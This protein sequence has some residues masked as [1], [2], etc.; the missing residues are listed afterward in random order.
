MVTQTLPSNE[1]C[2]AFLNAL[3]EAATD[4]SDWEAQFIESNTD[5]EFFTD[6]QK[7]SIAKM[8]T[9]YEDEVKW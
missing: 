8:M 2:R 5:R 3:D 4:I 1:D 9:K 7:Q 6:P